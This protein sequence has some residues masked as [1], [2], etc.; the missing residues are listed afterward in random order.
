MARDAANPD[1]ARALA[2]KPL[3]TVDDTTA[4]ILAANGQADQLLAWFRDAGIAC[5]LQRRAGPADL[6]V[7]NFGDPSP[8]EE[9]LIRRAFARWQTRNL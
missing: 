7:I 3:L 2:R 9:R 1:D 5:I 4:H 8:A 6:D